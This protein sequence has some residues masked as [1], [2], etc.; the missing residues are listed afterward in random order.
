MAKSLLVKQVGGVAQASL[1]QRKTL[2]AIG[3]SGIGS[4]VVRSDTRA[5]RGMLNQVQYLLEAEQVEKNTKAPVR[6]KLSSSGYKL[7]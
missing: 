4:S 3:L 5:M 1:R 2:K 7:G 6:K